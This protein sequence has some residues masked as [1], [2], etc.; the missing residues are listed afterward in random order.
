MNFPH[1]H[2]LTISNQFKDSNAYKINKPEHG[3]AA[4]P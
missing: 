4:Q 3:L 2:Q 1:S